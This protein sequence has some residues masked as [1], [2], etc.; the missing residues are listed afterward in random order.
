MFC[1][2]DPPL[3]LDLPE[4]VTGILVKHRLYISTEEFALQAS[5]WR[6]K[7][8]IWENTTLLKV[9]IEAARPKIIFGSE[10]VLSYIYDDFHGEEDTKGDQLSCYCV[11]VISK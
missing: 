10:K 8:S 5:G 11:L 1:L 2:T 6:A 4:A 3:C 9:W 7:Y